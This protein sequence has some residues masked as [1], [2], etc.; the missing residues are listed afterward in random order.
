MIER[1]DGDLSL[2][3]F[4]WNEGLCNPIFPAYACNSFACLVTP[5][6]FAGQIRKCNILKILCFYKL[7]ENK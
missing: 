6:V 1:K 5:S 2:P 3:G 4:L 7:R